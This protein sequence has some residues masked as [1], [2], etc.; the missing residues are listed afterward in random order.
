MLTGGGTFTNLN[1]MQFWGNPSGLPA[2]ATFIGN[3]YMPAN[4]TFRGDANATLVIDGVLSGGAGTVT[5]DGNMQATAVIRLSGSASN[6]FSGTWSVSKGTTELN[7][8]G[9]AIAIPTNITMSA[10]T[11]KWLADEQVADGATVTMSGSGKL[12]MNGFSDWVRTLILGGVTQA[13]GT[14]GGT[15]SGAQ[16]TNT[17]YFTAGAG[18]LRVGVKPLAAPCGTTFVVR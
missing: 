17:T 16:F 6:T 14:W 13:E 5:A 8:S 10:G 4:P 11:V 2:T 15:G 7:K 18:M 12:N 9:G 1:A 3:W